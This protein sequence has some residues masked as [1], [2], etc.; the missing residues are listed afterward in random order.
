MHRLGA[1][2]QKSKKKRAAG[3]DFASARLGVR[4]EIFL[5]SPV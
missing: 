5:G 1:E 2:T 3:F 4:F